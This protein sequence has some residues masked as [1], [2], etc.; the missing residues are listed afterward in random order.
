[1]PHGVRGT[2]GT[3]GS[4]LGERLVLNE[5]FAFKDLAVLKPHLD[6]LS[7]TIATVR[8]CGFA[9]ISYGGAFRSAGI[10]RARPRTASTTRPAGFAR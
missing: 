5:F 9:N 3:I 1:M 7:F 2:I 6:P 4:L 10:G 8:L